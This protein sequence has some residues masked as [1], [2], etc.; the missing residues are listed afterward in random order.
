MSG[1]EAQ[2]WAPSAA[3]LALWVRALRFS[4]YDVWLHYV[5]ITGAADFLEFSAILESALLA[6]D[7]ELALIEHAI[8]ELQEFGP[9]TR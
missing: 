6:D 1:D 3:F 5:S 2:H 4:H 7:S 9:G 8:W